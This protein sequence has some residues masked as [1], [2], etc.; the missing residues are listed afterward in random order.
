MGAP[1]DLDGGAG[2]F[3]D[4]M[5]R[6]KKLVYKNR[7]RLR[8]A[9]GRVGGARVGRRR[10]ALPQLPPLPGALQR[11]PRP[12]PPARAQTS[13]SILTACARARSTPTTSCA[14]CRW[15]ASTGRCRPASSRRGGRDAGDAGGGRGRRARGRRD[16]GRG[17]CS[18]LGAAAAPSP[19][20]S[21]S[22]GLPRTHSPPPT[23]YPQL[24]CEHYTVP[25]TASSDV[26]LYARLLDDVDAIFTKKVGARGEGLA[27]GSLRP[28]AA[29]TAVAARRAVPPRA[30]ARRRGR[31]RAPPPPPHLLSRARAP[32]PAATLAPGADAAGGGRA[33]A[34]RA[35][36][37]HA[38]PDQQQ[39][40]REPPPP[41]PSA[42]LRQ[43]PPAAGSQRP[44]P[45]V[46]QTGG[47][48]V[49][50]PRC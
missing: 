25:K 12:R 30:R 33:R 32:P 31:G 21:A 49:A 6:L 9:R 38:L 2:T 18:P 5:T 10:R 45:P 13:W 15:P 48:P 46:L 50:E 1:E 44:T 42:A 14:R 37:P 40:R 19:P 43:Q 17:A 20:R 8:G 23:P 41:Q 28:A 26:M 7:I 27:P 47:C 35:A 16:P 29:L 22:P 36:G 3:D 4:A 24:I 11:P 39:A 34:Q